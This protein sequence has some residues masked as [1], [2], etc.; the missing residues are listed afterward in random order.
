MLL[1]RIQRTLDEA[2]LPAGI[3]HVAIAVSGGADSC[4]AALALHRLWASRGIRLTLVHVDHGLRGAED[5]A[6]T[7]FVQQ[8]AATLGTGFAVRVVDVR[9]EMAAGGTS[10]EMAA[11]AL[12]HEALRH[13][14]RQAGADALA[15]GH[16]A[17]DQLETLLLRLGRGAGLRGLGGMAPAEPAP[18]GDGPCIV[19]PL[20]DCPREAIRDWLHAEGVT[21]R[22]DPTNDGDETPRNRLRH[23]VVPALLAALGPS[24][25]DSALRTMALARDEDR[26]WLR[27]LAA[28]A[29]SR[30][31]GPDGS[32]RCATLAALPRPLARRA[33]LA[34]LQAVGMPASAQTLAAVD[35]LLALAG[36]PDSGTRSRDL[37]AG[38]RA[39]RVY[40]SLRVETDR[41]MSP[42]H[43]GGN[44]R[45]EAGFGAVRPHRTDPLQRPAV[46]SISRTAVPDPSRLSVRPI[47]TGDR[48]RP[49]GAGGFRAVADILV[50]RKVPREARPHVEVVCLDKRIAWLPGHAV[51]EAFA[52]ESPRAP[53][54]TLTL[55]AP[56]ESVP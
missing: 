13:A 6:D 31:K 10:L 4:A 3:R 8:F 41:P 27:P 48:L 33:A 22:D 56:E 38:F 39:V 23:H 2:G 40:G 54:W 25:R 49:I 1:A 19:R 5:D 26:L 53:S 51:D 35:R 55:T 47:Q 16:N 37:G 15:F 24:A 9:A 17:D 30:A 29:L 43:R 45:V 12:R 46:A 42:P 21:W 7:T 34:H 50:D 20:L 44:L 52:V 11:R 36:G 28:E 32:L 18:D 14:T